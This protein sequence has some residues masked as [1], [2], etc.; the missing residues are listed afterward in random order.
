MDSKQFADIYKDAAPMIANGISRVLGDI[1]FKFP[2]NA[3]IKAGE[4]TV[5]TS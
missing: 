3:G 5:V 1:T 2:A 4:I